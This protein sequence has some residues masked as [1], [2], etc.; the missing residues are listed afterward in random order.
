MDRRLEWVQ[1]KTCL[2]LGIAPELFE[3]AISNTE[4]RTR[5][6]SFLDGAE[7]TSALLFALEEATIYVEEYQDVLVEEQD[8]SFHADGEETGDAESPDGDGNEGRSA[9]DGGDNRTTSGVSREASAMGERPPSSKG[10]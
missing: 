3:Q 10:D 2:G 7:A 8:P 4:N 6:T 1:E 9:S 5:V